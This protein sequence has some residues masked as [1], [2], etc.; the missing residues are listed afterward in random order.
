MVPSGQDATP[1]SSAG[2]LASGSTARVDRVAPCDLVFKDE[3]SAALGVVVDTDERLENAAQDGTSWIGGCLFRVRSGDVVAPLEVTLAIGPPYLEAYDA[4]HGG[5]V[6][7]ESGL[8]DEA[9]LLLQ[10]VWGLE[11]PLGSLY[12]R[13]GDAVLGFQL[14]VTRIGD[15]GSPL[16]VGDASAQ[17]AALRELAGIALG[18]L[19][20]PQTTRATCSLVDPA[21]ASALAGQA[22][23]VSIARGE[24][25]DPHDVWGPGCAYLDAA[26]T[27]QL[28]VAVSDRASAAPNFDT[29]TTTL[30]KPVSGIG[31]AAFFTRSCQVVAKFK[32]MNDPMIIARSG[33]TVVTVTM[34]PPVGSDP[35]R[36]EALQTWVADVA[37]AVLAKL[38][39]E[40]A[41]T[42]TPG[43]PTGADPLAKPCSVLTNEE[44]S[45]GVKV[46]V[47]ATREDPGA[48]GY[49]AHCF[50]SD[51][52]F[53]F[54]PLDFTIG[55]GPEA[56]AEFQA[57][58]SSPSEYVA[59]PG[60]GDAAYQYAQW[61]FEVNSTQMLRLFVRRGD[62]VVSLYLHG[63]GWVGQ[64]GGEQTAPGD[65]AAQLVILRHF[66]ELILSRI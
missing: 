15:D 59:V 36:Y 42:P 34:P 12:V 35:A 60:L 26:G 48:P 52:T 64:A 61:T 11:G 3:V 9:L 65:V 17:A 38:G 29:C 22:A 16:L 24:D 4:L 23:G 62:T 6:R 41:A 51:A 46:A 39:A 1:A 5:P 31:D 20:T 14:G 63:N 28:Y 27:M 10:D 40:P 33:S 45:A 13:I 56:V 43:P 37:R 66:A 53:S 50:Y 58:A 47:T 57:F 25:V 32:Y 55:V 30:A 19:T 44:A 8:G 18:R 2:P 54:T 21:A 49:P 7:G